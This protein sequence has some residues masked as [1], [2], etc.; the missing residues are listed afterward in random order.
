MPPLISSSGTAKPYSIVVDDDVDKEDFAVFVRFLY[1]YEVCKEL[2]PKLRRSL[3][4][5]ARKY[6]VVGLEDYCRSFLKESISC[7]NVLLYLEEAIQ[8]NLEDSV[9][10]IDLAY[11]LSEDVGPDDDYNR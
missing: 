9:G 2:T 3:V 1:L 11:C 7:K 4:L 10:E 5:L 8:Q 6:L